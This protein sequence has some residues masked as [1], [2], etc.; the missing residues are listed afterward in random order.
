MLGSLN[1]QHGQGWHV[2][3]L[4]LGQ[5][6]RFRKLTESDSTALW[7]CPST[8]A[9]FGA[10]PRSPGLCVRVGRL[11]RAWLAGGAAARLC[12]ANAGRCLVLQ[13]RHRQGG[14]HTLVRCSAGGTGMRRRPRAAHPAGRQHSGLPPTVNSRQPCPPT[15]AP[16]PAV[17]PAAC[18]A[19]TLRRRK[20]RSQ[21]R[22][23]G[24]SSH[25]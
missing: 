22:R 3:V 8:M 4:R 21:K 20:A 1:L 16:P 11:E 6:V 10:L 12:A 25:W 15:H 5:G 14:A 13:C 23:L 19:C 2:Q 24:R 9:C 17:V 18:T 7:R